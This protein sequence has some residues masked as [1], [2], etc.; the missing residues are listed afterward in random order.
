MYIGDDYMGVIENSYSVIFKN[1]LR[2][3]NPLKKKVIKTE[4][5]VHKFITNQAL[6]ILK[7]DKH[8]RAYEMLSMYIDDLNAGVVWADQDFKSSNHFYNPEKD[9]GMYGCSNALKECRHYY[10]KALKMYL[11]RNMKGAMFYLGAACHLIQD[12]TVPQ[13]VNVRLLDQH[14]KYE[15]WVIKTYKEHDNFKIYSGGIYL[16]SIDEYARLNARTAISTYR[17]YIIENN[18]Q[19]RYYKTT[20]IVLAMAQK[21]TA[22]LLMKFFRDIIKNKALKSEY[23]NKKYYKVRYK[24]L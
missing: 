23:R 22:G 6:E 13:H 3:V 5:E 9:R 1:V 24:G 11:R 20:M 15:Q 19:E 10:N 14:R 21:T 8:K 16:N 18:R 12:L 4:C 17:K 7:N 2:A